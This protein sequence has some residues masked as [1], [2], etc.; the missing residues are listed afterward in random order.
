[1]SALNN[2]IGVVGVAPGSKPYCVKVLDSTGAGSD[3]NIIAGLDWIYKNWN[4]VTPNIRVVNMSLGRAGTISDNS[5]Y[6]TAIQKLY[7][8]GIVI[9]TAA[10]NDQ[11]V[12]VTKRVPQAYP[13]VI[14]VASTTAL[15]G[16]TSC[17]T[18]AAIAADSASYFTTDGKFDPTTKIG[19]TI[20]APGEDQENIG[21]TCTATSIGM[22]SLN[23]GGG[24]IRYSGSSISSPL[25]AGV[26]ARMLQKGVSGVENVRTQLRSTA[27]KVGTAPLDSRITGYTFD[28]EREGIAKAP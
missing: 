12:D 1:V 24:T 15:A 7:N 14:N 21:S 26:V 10:G 6:R 20:S 16:T 5:T 18:Q 2:T 28:G 4:L 23:K 9:V 22:L 3:S 11:T 19:V 17:K 25:V 27:Q 13:E 8:L